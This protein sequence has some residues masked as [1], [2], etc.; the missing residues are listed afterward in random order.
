MKVGNAR[1]TAKSLLVNSNGTRMN[2]LVPDSRE[3]F[4]SYD[5]SGSTGRIPDH[6]LEKSREI[7]EYL[8]FKDKP[9]K[10]NFIKDY[11]IDYTANSNLHGLKYIGEKE[12][13]IVEKIFWLF[14]FICCLVICAGLIGKLWNKWNVNPVIVSFAE[15]PTPVYQIP[16]PAVTLCFETK[17]MQRK[18]NFTE[19]YHLYNNTETYSN[20]TEQERHLFE[21]VSMVCDDHLAPRKGRKT[22]SG[23]ELVN[24]ITEIS[25]NL[26][27]VFL[28][29]KWKDITKPN[30]SDLF[31]PIITE[32]GLCYTF[33]TLGNDELF[34]TE[35]LHSD[36]R[37]LEHENLVGS[38]SLDGGYEPNTPIETYP[39]RGSGYGAKSGLT[40]LLKAANLDL[41]YLCKGPVQG[42]KILLHNPAELPRVSQQYFRSPLS[43]EVVV[44]VKPKMM[45]TSEGLRPYEAKRRLCYFPNERYLRYFKVYTQANC[46]MECLS[47]FTYTRCGCVHFGMPHDSNMSVCN[48]GSMP[49]IKHAQMDL[50]TIAIETG[51]DDSFDADALDNAKKVSAKCDCLPSC[52]S[53]EYEAETSQADFDCLALFRAFRYNVSEF[54]KDVSYARIMI[55]FKEAQFI[56]SRRSEL[57][58]QTDFLANSG[59]LLGLFMG[60]SFLSLIEIVYF[61]SLRIICVLFKRKNKKQMMNFPKDNLTSPEFYKSS[62]E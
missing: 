12:R 1:N 56:T 11:I 25:P 59:G 57:Y 44:A 49:C 2:A 62:N 21:D 26:T 33:N 4:C 7:N 16:Y 3:N 15:N 14:A 17:A 38:W 22:S 18:F 31:S 5:R 40:M 51:L 43:Q 36:Y 29:C 42:F 55:F 27:D 48:A 13:T 30:C 24:H 32:E 61:L 9:K 39:H 47:N 6:D 46:E 45:T 19:Y 37:Y 23:Y 20:L 8:N 10:S 58:G 52:T 50:V 35:N 28:G 54:V 34:R 41:D 53:I 60:F